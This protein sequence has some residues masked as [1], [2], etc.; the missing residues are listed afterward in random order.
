MERQLPS[1]AQ[2]VASCG[3]QFTGTR[4]EANEGSFLEPVARTGDMT[5]RKAGSSSHKAICASSY[6]IK[7]WL[8]QRPDKDHWTPAGK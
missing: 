7:R 5:G 4:R 8:E 3:A 6:S 2:L 1:D